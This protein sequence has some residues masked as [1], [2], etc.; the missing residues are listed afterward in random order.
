MTEGKGGFVDQGFDGRIPTWN[1]LQGTYHRFI[2]DMKWW[3]A[4]ED[5]A[6]SSLTQAAIKPKNR[7][8]L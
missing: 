8:Y 3:E 6:E 1:G 2:K 4:G 7:A 5:F